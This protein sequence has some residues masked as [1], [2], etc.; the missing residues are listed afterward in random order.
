MNLILLEPDDVDASG[1]ATLSGPRAAHLRQVLRVEPGRTVRVGLIDGPCGTATVRAA[2]QRAVT[3]SCVFETDTP[4]RPSVDL[5]LALPRPKV[6]GRLWAQLAA[7]GVGRIVLTN[8]ARVERHYFDT[9]VL[10]P[11]HYRPRLVEGLQQSRDT[12]LPHV[13]IHRQLKILIEDHLDRLCGVGARALADPGA[14]APIRGPM[15]SGERLLLAIGPEGGWNE[16][17]RALLMAHGFEP[18]GMGRRTL[19]S[20]TACIALLALAHHAV[21]TSPPTASEPS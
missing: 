19:R 2:D 8:A 18:V 20:D 11:D 14:S 16:Y 17:E 4:A 12:R 15:P 3:L 13:S 5:L 9:H 10:A 1:Q 6:M 7:L 21:T